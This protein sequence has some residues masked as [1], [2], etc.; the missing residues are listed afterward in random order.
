MNPLKPR[1]LLGV[2]KKLGFQLVHVRGSHYIFRNPEGKRITIPVHKGK[3]I[4]QGLLVK[5]IKE[6][7]NLSVEEFEKLL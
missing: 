5:I 4:G 1:K 6:D 7:L 3:L 2:V